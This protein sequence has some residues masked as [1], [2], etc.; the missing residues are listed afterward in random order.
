MTD[1]ATELLKVTEA[2]APEPEPAAVLV[3][4]AAMVE[5]W[6]EIG[7]P[8][9]QLDECCS[10]KNLEEY[11]YSGSPVKVRHLAAIQKVLDE[12]ASV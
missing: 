2:P 12:G 3:N 9:I 10:V 1:P 5:R 8:K 7:S 6:R 4:R 11:L